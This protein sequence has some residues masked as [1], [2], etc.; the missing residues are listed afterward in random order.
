MQWF[1]LGAQGALMGFVAGQA[2]EGAAFLGVLFANAFL[3][4]WYG[5]ALKRD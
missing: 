4:V 1:L 2:F 5:L 3:V